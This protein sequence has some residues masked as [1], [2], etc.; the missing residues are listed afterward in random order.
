MTTTDEWDWRFAYHQLVHANLNQFA[1]GGGQP[2]ITGGRLKALEVQLPPLAEQ[3]RIAAALDAFDDLL[4]DPVS[5]L[6]AEIAARGKQFEYYRDRLLA[7]PR[8][9]ESESAA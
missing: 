9:A 5:G 4:N 2:L 7:L 3:R 8:Q 1:V 6:P